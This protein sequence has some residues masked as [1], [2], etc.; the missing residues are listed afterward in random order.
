MA[1]PALGSLSDA[2]TAF[3]VQ[4]FESLKPR[5]PDGEAEAL[6]MLKRA[7]WQVQPLMKRRQWRILVLRELEPE[8]MTRGARCRTRAL[9][10]EVRALPARCA[11][12]LRRVRGACCAAGDNYNRGEVVRIKV[13]RRG[14][15][16]EAYEHVLKVLLHELCHNEHGPH[17]ASFYKLLDDITQ[18]RRRVCG[19]RKRKTQT[20]A[21]L[22]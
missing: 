16:F 19:A 20:R 15:G 14:G 18:A 21:E 10:L 6:E 2:A 13:R 9:E 1:P 12:R 7:A 17:S 4:A 8:N 22:R 5:R 3:C 11:L